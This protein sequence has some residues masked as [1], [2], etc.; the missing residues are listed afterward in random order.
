MVTEKT[1]M[2]GHVGGLDPVPQCGHSCQSAICTVSYLTAMV[3]RD[4]AATA[5]AKG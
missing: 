1:V 3:A 2:S 5:G 4:E